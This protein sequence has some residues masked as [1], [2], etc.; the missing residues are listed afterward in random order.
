MSKVSIIGGAGTLG[1]AIAFTLASKPVV[2]EICLIDVNENLLLNHIMDFQNAYPAKTIYKGSYNDLKGT[3]I[4]IITAGIPNRNDINSRN[5]FLEGNLKLFQTFGREISLH[6]PNAI[7][8]TASNPVDILNYYL[9]TEY[10]F[11]RKKLIGY[12]L[13]DSKRFEWGL[14]S[15]L[16]ISNNDQ[17]YSP[18]IGEHGSTQ[19]PL[20]SQVKLNGLPLNISKED[21][22]LVKEKLQSW[23]IDFNNLQINRTTG[24]TTAVGL[25]NVVDKLLVDESSELIGSAILEGEYGISNVSLGVPIT[26]NKEGIQRINNWEID[27]V[28]KDLL[29]YSANQVKNT[30]NEF[31]IK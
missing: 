23:F 26:V 2:E 4:I 12:T 18:V 20:F 25:S 11:E 10:R 28:E 19:V 17:V 31:A 27:Q 30:F 5:V 22:E 16:P 8:V 14:R 6:A 21:K 3:D 24:W 15:I 29:H 1:A 9:F 7:I 13:N